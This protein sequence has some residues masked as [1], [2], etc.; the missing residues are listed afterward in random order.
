MQSFIVVDSLIS[1]LAGGQKVLNV[2]KNT[3]KG[4]SSESGHHVDTWKN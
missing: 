2:K 3:V 4:L 1:E